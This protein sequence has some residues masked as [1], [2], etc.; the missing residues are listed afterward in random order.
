ILTRLEALGAVYC[1]STGAVST[2]GSALRGCAEPQASA[3]SASSPTPP[4][5]HSVVS[6]VASTPSRAPAIPSAPSIPS[7]PAVGFSVVPDIDLS[8]DEQ[9]AIWTAWSSLEQK[10]HYD[11]LGVPRDAPRSAIQEAYFARVASVHPDKHFG[12]RLGTYK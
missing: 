8:P 10:N 4:E 11:L 9:A 6:G 2:R 3:V 7:A 12:R 5:T 1:S